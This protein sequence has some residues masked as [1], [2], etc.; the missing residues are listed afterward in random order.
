M[1]QQIELLN[2]ESHK[3][4]RMRIDAGV[5]HPNF[6]P[7]VM[8]EFQAASNS[9]PIFFAKDAGTGEFYAAALFGFQPGEM[10]ADS[11][12]RGVAD[13]H[14]LDLQRQ[15]FFASEQ[16]IAVDPAHPRFGGGATIA[17]FEEDGTPSNAMRKIQRVTG[18]LAT[19]IEATQSFISE[20]LRLKLIEPVDISLR[21]DDGES[22]TLDG[23]YTVSRD[24]LND[25]EDS[26][27][28]ALFRS[29][30]LQ[31]ALCMTF[32]LSQVAILAQRRNERLTANL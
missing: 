9:C 17:L 19:G 2:N 3:D 26:A 7:V 29:G 14:P 11:A 10:L 15:G 28:L 20:L 25:L 8:S 22:L 23:L 31:A 4:L 6:V 16:N 21:F 13:F 27:I 18:Q 5:P 12:K 32:S 24:G 30:Y 1:T